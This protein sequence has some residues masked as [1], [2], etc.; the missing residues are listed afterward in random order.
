[1]QADTVVTKGNITEQGQLQLGMKPQTIGKVIGATNAPLMVMFGTM[2]QG[3][4]RV[5]GADSVTR[6]V[7][8]YG[9]PQP[10]IG[11]GIGTTNVLTITTTYGT[12][13]RITG[14]VIGATN[15]PTTT[16]F[17][18]PPLTAAVTIRLKE[19]QR[20]LSFLPGLCVQNPY[21]PGFK[22]LKGCCDF[23]SI[24]D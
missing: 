23:L 14:K 6:T 22:F 1:L 18:V 3:I 13:Q 15:V 5:I 24:S 10:T 17:G 7:I 2:P 20:T 19:L 11:Q 9:T 21:R 8:P 4:G 16:T 12:P